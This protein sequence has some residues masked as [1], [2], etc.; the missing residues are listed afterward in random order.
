MYDSWVAASKR[1]FELGKAD[2]VYRRVD[3]LLLLIVSIMQFGVEQQP[4]GPTILLR[5]HPD[6]I[7]SLEEV[8]K[9]FKFPTRTVF[10][11]QP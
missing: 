11:E 9:Y 4:D 3:M 2:P 5:G 10:E 8:N 7:L 1:G 6:E